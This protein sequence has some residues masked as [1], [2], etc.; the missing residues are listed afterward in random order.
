MDSFVDGSGYLAA[1]TAGLPTHG[2]L[3][4][5]RAD[6]AEWEHGA[7]SP[8]AYGA[9]VEEGRSLFAR[10]VGV[11]PARVATGSQTS[12]MVAVAA[13]A[14]PDGAEVVVPDGDFSSVVFPFL[15]QA[16]R[17]VHVRSVPLDR[18]AE[19]V[20]PG[21]AMVAWSAVQSSS[22]AVTE[23]EPVVAAARAAGA[24]TLCDLTQAAGVLPVSAAPVDVTVTHAY[25]WLCAP[26]GVAF[27]TFSDEA[28]ARLRPV[29]AG[30]YAGEDLWSSCYGPDMRLAADARRFDVSPA[31][32]A[33]PGAVAALRHLAAVDAA[34]AWRHATGLTDRL[35][36]ALGSPRNG[37]AITTFP[38]ADGSALRALTDA[39]LTA[40]GRA[41]R[42]R[43]AF[44]LWN[45]D[46]DVTRVVDVL[47]G[48]SGFRP[49]G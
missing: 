22:G 37:Q 24:L 33:W 21:T 45:D 41:G 1:C 43:L 15:A 19:E 6:L 17:G 26:R 34:S 18:L 23:P 3:A 10:I 12:A 8:L 40:S 16:H 28:L 20:R 2:T 5:M 7:S 44:H 47:G 31:W 27:A 48:L 9:L 4:A 14:L 13:A 29:Q 30:W 38:D 25:K 36:D 42:L 39:G 11:D 46:A 49:V 35:A 32:Q